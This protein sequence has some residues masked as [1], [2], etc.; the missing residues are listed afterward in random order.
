[1][2]R[3]WDQLFTNPGVIVINLEQL[4]IDTYKVIVVHNFQ[5]EDCNPRLNECLAGVFL[6]RQIGDRWEEPE[7]HPTECRSIA[8]LGYLDTRLL[9]TWSP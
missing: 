7:E 4:P 9:R 6:A 5:V 2:L 8:V 1:M 3:K